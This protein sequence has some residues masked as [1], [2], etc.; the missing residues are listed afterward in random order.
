MEEAHDYGADALRCV[1]TIIGYD[2][3]TWG[4]QFLSTSSL[5]SSFTLNTHLLLG[6]QRGDACCNQDANF[7]SAVG[8]N[9]NMRGNPFSFV[10][11]CQ[12]LLF[13]C[14]VPK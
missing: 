3:I 14:T 6:G 8:L 11:L 5:T 1:R 9:D 2:K 12:L 13:C 7:P 10:M 4:G